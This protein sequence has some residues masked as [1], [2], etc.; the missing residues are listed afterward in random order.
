MISKYL[1]ELIDSNNRII[2]PDLGAFMI[3]DSPSGKQITFNDFL[4]FNDGL[5]INQIIKTE[6]I[7]KSEAT[8]KIKEFAKAVEKSFT[9]GK[10]YEIKGVGLLLKDSHNN[11]KFE[12]KGGG[13]TEVKPSATDEKPTIVLDEKSKSKEEAKPVKKVEVPKVKQEK[14]PEVKSVK[15]EVKPRAETTK[16]EPTIIQ[17]TPKAKPVVTSPSKV[18]VKT[19]TTKIISKPIDK[20]RPAA[21]AQG[22]ND[23]IMKTLIIIIAAIIVLGGGTW[24][25]FHFDLKD[26]FGK[27][28]VIEPAVEVVEP[29]VAADTIAED[30]VMEKPLVV[31][32]PAVEPVDDNRTKYYLIGGS[33]KVVSNANGFNQKLIDEG[34][35]SEIIIRNNGF[36]C[37]SFKYFYTWDEV[38]SEWRKMKGENSEIWILIR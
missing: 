35:D 21:K 19:P 14:K 22:S 17:V 24:A 9:D 23:D 1:R 5:L 36:H 31:E 33:F 29:I 6:K 34:F 37:V 26:R 20:K 30:T 8:D 10:S 25:F 13:V 16:V 7:S 12:S 28:E 38:V 27:T 3:Q 4:K 18:A 2:I 32:E 11:I 15:E